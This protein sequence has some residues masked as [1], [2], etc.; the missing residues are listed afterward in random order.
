M[1][2]NYSREEIKQMMEDR[3][4]KEDIKQIAIGMLEGL[5][6]VGFLAAGYVA[7]WLLMG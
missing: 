2:F 1:D 5:V 3:Y 6:F 4:T 7:I